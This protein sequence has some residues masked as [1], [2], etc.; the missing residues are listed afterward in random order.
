MTLRQLGVRG[1][2]TEFLLARER[3]LALFVPAGVERALVLRDP[4]RR[5]VM[6]RV[7]GTGREVHEERL[8]G[9]QRLLLAHPRDRLVGQVLGEVVALLRRLFRLDRR[10]PLIQR[11]VPLVVLAAD[12]A[13]EV[14]KARTGRPHPERT[15]RTR[16]PDRDLVALAELRGRVAVELEGLCERRLR[17]RTQRVLPRRRRRG[18]GDAPHPDRVMVAAR[19]QRRPR[20]RAQRGRVKARVLQALATEPLERRRATRAT[21]RT[22]RPEAHVV[23]QHDQHV[24]RALRRPQRDDRRKR[25]VRVLGVVRRQPGRRH[26]RNRQDL[27]LR[28]CVIGHGALSAARWISTRGCPRRS[29][30]ASPRSD[31]F[32]TRPRGVIT[33]IG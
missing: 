28:R 12:E 13:V 23:E 7:R 8:V 20:R 32:G 18:L 29:A 14:L 30:H 16:L 22:R 33:R 9:H 1:D 21:E 4:L 11:G 2:D 5:H 10:R 3:G 19:Q 17:V 15:H 25:R 31:D 26:V 24:R 6:R 27:A